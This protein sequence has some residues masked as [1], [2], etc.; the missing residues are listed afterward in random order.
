MTAPTLIL[1]KVP[2]RGPGGVYS[3]SLISGVGDQLDVS[4]RYD[5]LLTRLGELGSVLVAYSGGVDSTLLSVAAHAVLG[6]RCLSVLAVSDVSSQSETD[7]A[8][9]LARNLGL[10]FLEVETHELIDPAF[11]ENSADRCYY[12][13]SELFGLLARVAEARGLA[14]VADGSNAD[15][16]SDHRPGRR[17]GAE[18]GIVS[19]L[20]EAGLTK[21]E[22][23]ELAR[24]LGLPNWNKPS[25]ACLASRFPYGEPISEDRLAMVAGAEAALRKLGLRQ[26]RVRA[27]G[28]VAR[29]EVEAADMDRAWSM[30]GPISD[31][32]KRAGFAYVAQDLD[33]YRSGSLNETLGH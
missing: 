5:A 29:V 21:E 26:F 22:I 17:A 9:S 18:Y 28:D 6:D 12:C 7:K 20:Q 13:K 15:D 4:G 16:A 30:R 2:N 10:S 11:R 32:V 31:A 33:G 1:P 14:Y 3:K 19:P 23:R 24:S 25:M 27:H 8:R